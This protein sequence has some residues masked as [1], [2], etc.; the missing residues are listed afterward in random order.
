MGDAQESPK[1]TGEKLVSLHPLNFEEA[2]R[3]LL[4]TPPAGKK[5]VKKAKKSKK[6]TESEN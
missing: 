3:G 1:A 4:A 2:L 5:K 6:S